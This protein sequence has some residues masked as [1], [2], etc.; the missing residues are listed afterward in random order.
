MCELLAILQELHPDVDFLTHNAL[1]DGK[2][3]DSFDVIELVSEINDRMDVTIP[4][5][6]LIP[7][8]FNTYE[9]LKALVERLK[10]E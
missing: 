3:I 4:A 1:I 9:T 10:D 5:E 7:E 8:N 6:E 2:V